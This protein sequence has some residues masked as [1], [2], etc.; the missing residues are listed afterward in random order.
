LL[1]C[2]AYVDLNPIRAAIAQTL[3]TSDHTSVQ[4]RIEAT[5]RSQPPL[6]EPLSLQQNVELEIPQVTSAPTN[7]IDAGFLAPLTIDEAKD[8]VGP[9]V[10]QT[11]KRASDKGFLPMSLVDYLQLLDW[12]ARE[13]RP[14]KAG[15][16]GRDV[17]PVIARLGLETTAWT[18]LVRDFGKLFNSVAGHPDNVD[19]LRS[20]RTQRRFHLR[21]RVREL[22]PSVQ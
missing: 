21:R 10:S 11:G 14:D 7:R 2:A 15:Y 13:M 18:E 6:G 19:P 12:T 8:D 1:A 3:E 9:C 5:L 16:T 17:P 20:G 4:C 22:M